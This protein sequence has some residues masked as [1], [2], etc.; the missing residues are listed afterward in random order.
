MTGLGGQ[1]LVV[2]VTEQ[3]IMN[4]YKDFY[5]LCYIMPQ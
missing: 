2:L 1:R 3:V 4:A 5:F